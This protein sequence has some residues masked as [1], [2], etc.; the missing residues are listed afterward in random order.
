MTTPLII[1]TDPGI[2]DVAAL[3]ISLFAEKLAVRLLVPTWGNAALEYTLQNTLNLEKFLGSKVPVIEGAS[4]PLLAPPIN[5]ADVHGQTGLN[6]YHFA[7][8]GD[9]L[10]NP[11]LAATAMYNEIMDSPQKVTLLGIGPLTDYALLLRQYPNVIENIA[12]IVLMGGSLG[13]GN[14]SPF[15]EFNIAADPEAAQIILTSNLPVKLVPL[16]IGDQ[17]RLNKEDLNQIGATGE[18]GNML[19]SLFS[20]LREPDKQLKIY[21]PTAVAMLLQ[22]DIFTLHSASVKIELRGQYTYG[23]SVINFTEQKTKVQVAT[24]VNVMAFKEWFI[25]AIRKAEQGRKIN[26]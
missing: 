24:S 11:I 6:G 20:H 8:A 4:R 14:H 21:D 1:S 2:D 16:E 13:R 9:D 17:T 23:A 7:E 26:G 3:T 10:V 15:T 19:A 12:Q 22:P 25:R 18:V 5:A